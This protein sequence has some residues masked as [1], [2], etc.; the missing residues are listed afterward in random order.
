MEDEVIKEFLIESNENLARLDQEFVLLEKQHDDRNLLGSIFRTIHTIKGTAGFFNF[1]K[2]VSITHFGEDILSKMRDGK[3]KVTPQIIDALLAGVDAVK[4]VLSC[5]ETD[6]TEGTNE[7]K[8]VVQTL[9]RIAM[10][11][12]VALAGDR[13]SR[14]KKSISA[15]PVEQPGA[16]EET[17][18]TPV[19]QTRP[20]IKVAPAATPS[21]L[22]NAAQKIA[23]AFPPPAESIPTAKAVPSAQAIPPAPH[24]EDEVAAPAADPAV[25]ETHA[26]DAGRSAA[27]DSTIR[28]EVALLDR[29]MNLVGELVLTRNQILQYAG[30]SE[31]KAILSSSQRL[32]LITTE[33]QENVMKTRM[34]PINGVWNKLP[35][36]VRDVSQ[37]LGKE[38]DLQMEGATTELDKTILEAVKD[39]FTHIV[40]NAIDHGIESPEE[41]LKKGK[42]RRGLVK[43]RAFHEGGQVNIEV[44]DDGGGISLQSVKRKAVKSGLITEEHALRMGE[45]EA[46]HLIFSPGFSTAEK[47]TAISGRGVGMDVVKT[48]IERIGGVVDILNNP[49]HGTTIK[50]K[51][52]LTLA[53]IPALIVTANSERFAIPQI[54]LREL[55]RL[56]GDAARKGIEWVQGIEVYRLRGNLLPL[57]RLRRV[58]K[59]DDGSAPERDIVNIVVLFADNRLF[60]LVVDGV[61]DT[62]EIVVK[63]LSKQ[64]KNIQA[65]AGATIMGDGQVALILDTVGMMQSMQMLN[66]SAKGPEKDS[67]IVSDLSS[68]SS[69][70]LLFT[71]DDRSRF[72]MPLSMVSRLEEIPTSKIEHTSEREVIQYRG[73]V[74]P[75]IR[76]ASQFGI[77]VPPDGETL[78]VIVFSDGNRAIG[79]A[80]RRI[81]DVVDVSVKPRQDSVRPGI[82]GS[83]IIQGHTTIFVDPYALIDHAEPGFFKH[84]SS[85]SKNGKSHEEPRAKRVL[86]VDDSV[87]FRSLARSYLE[88]GGYSVIEASN[89]ADA[90]ERL[91]TQNID[92]IISDID[93]PEMDGYMLAARI[94]SEPNYRSLPM[95]ALTALDRATDRN[96]AIAAGFDGYEIKINR[97]RLL[98]AV[99]ELASRSNDKEAIL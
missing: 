12:S 65:F 9:Q 22:Q 17:A 4:E 76:M 58:L 47:V 89:G 8:E 18:P 92:L 96:K 1:T 72:A 13:P 38:V 11:E 60:G 80:V 91:K 66:E 90:L 44:S 82:I 62:E 86:H 29:L 19:S 85:R 70:L 79:V 36:L 98:A 63:P 67:K 37:S 28:V 40:R 77:P 50:I 88:I 52:P 27:A 46:L 15:A 20:S 31:N 16:V 64:L 41:R 68:S 69:T 26:A 57:L 43:L 45:R 59:L 21:D 93:M 87:F 32:N 75:L 56:E 2:L 14:L 74:M 6:G 49:T 97:D 78:P 99:T 83:A 51:I 95:L 53:I 24:G 73:E 39:P 54:N 34:Q 61:N 81:L 71:L 84:E 55:V 25:L 3:M 7:Y 42:D 35:R 33:L 10:G 23:A 48:N 5:I 30:C 94:R